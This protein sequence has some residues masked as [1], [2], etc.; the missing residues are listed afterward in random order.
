MCNNSSSKRETILTVTFTGIVNIH[1]LVLLVVE[2]EV[3]TS[4][5]QTHLVAMALAVVAVE[6]VLVAAAQVDETVG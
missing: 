4:G 3:L 6:T 1:R 2:L 5:A